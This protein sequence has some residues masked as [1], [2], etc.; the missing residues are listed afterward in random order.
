MQQYEAIEKGIADHDVKALREAVGSI[1]YTSRDFSSGEF[2]EAVRYVES[3]GIRLKDA[4][5]TGDPVVSGGKST[6]T[7]DDFARAVFELKRNFCEERIQDVKTI[8]RILYAGKAK[9]EIAESGRI[10]VEDRPAQAG[11]RPNG[12]S[13]QPG[14]ALITA[15]II[16]GL[17]A[18][19]ILWFLT[20]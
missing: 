5:L 17:V 12:Q 16:V 4:S 14:R 10:K 11:T 9:P 3:Q 18:A 15:L 8:G 20:T 13:H 6:F 7:D 2:D 19:A 1:C